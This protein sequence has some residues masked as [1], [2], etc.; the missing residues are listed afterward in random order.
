M[1]AK[2]NS[3]IKYIHAFVLCWACLTLVFSCSRSGYNGSGDDGGDHQGSENDTTYPVIR[4]DRPVANQVFSNGDTI[5]IEGSVTDNGLYRGK[6]RITN[7][8]NGAVINEQAYEIHFFTSY[9][10]SFSH[11][12]AVSVVSDY[13]VSVE[14][15]D[16]GLNTT[17][18]TV[19]VKVNP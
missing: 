8:L 10:F 2:R 16:H 17:T 5:K 9:N 12:T 4:I 7:D 11:K 14:F 1:K 19:K 13:T 15:E 3:S 18:K 6:I